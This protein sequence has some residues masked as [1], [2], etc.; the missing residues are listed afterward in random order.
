MKNS[1]TLL[2]GGTC[3]ALI[4]CSC[5]STS[6]NGG[7]EEATPMNEYTVADGEIP[8]WLLD[9]GEE[10]QVAATEAPR[11]N[12][13][14][15]E[16]PAE[17]TAS[18]SSGSSQVQPPLADQDDTTIETDTTPIA[19]TTPSA[20]SDPMLTPPAPE[21]TVSKPTTR[22]TATPKPRGKKITATATRK[23]PSKP[24]L[25]TYKVRPGDSLAVIAQ[26]NNT[27]IAQ[28]RKDSNLKS[29]TIHPGQTLKVRPMSRDP[30]K[31]TKPTLITYTVRPGDNLAT[32][33]ARSR[34]TVE[35]IRKDSKLK[36]S[37]I[38]PGQTIKVRY[39]PK[40]YKP[41]KSTKSRNR[42]K[43]YTVRKGDSL[44]A[45][46]ARN[47]ISTSA[48]MKANK[49]SGAKARKIMPGQKLTIPAK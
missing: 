28:I 22:P 44:G 46:A 16:P 1:V 40:G 3:I 34:T 29:N 23:K 42:A 17:A 5:S 9:D 25:I 14:I 39:T 32:I 31:F 8:V 15:P 38:H 24:K 12:Y 47:G 20:G 30:K 41:G 45:I 2:T 27:T 19:T 26:R 49:L 21:P 35:Q 11:N 18:R 13:P 10:D 43:T 33:A 4:L 37:V 6:S 48:L 36:S 7:Y